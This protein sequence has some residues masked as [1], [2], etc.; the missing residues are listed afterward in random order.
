MMQPS[1][2]FERIPR[3]D[4]GNP[5]RCGSVGTTSGDQCWFKAAPGTNPLR[6]ILHGSVQIA[7]QKREQLRMYNVGKIRAQLDELRESD[8]FH[9]LI[10]ELAILRMTLR[11]VLEMCEGSQ[12]IV[13]S[14]KITS[15]V[16]TIAKLMA[17]DT[18]QGRQVGELIDR[19]A[20]D[21][22]C[23]RIMQVMADY[24]PTDKLIEVGDRIAAAL[25]EAVDSS[26]ER[27]A[28]DGFKL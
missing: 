16:Q 2:K 5:E 8:D 27:V 4:P 13:H 12:L 26:V 19:K 25:A 10:E 21:M 11:S 18:K 20:M 24:L 14:G 28:Q 1:K 9:R 22:L 7:H 15:L 23:D 6:C 3:D 17:A